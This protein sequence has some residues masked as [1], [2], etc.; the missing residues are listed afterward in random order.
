MTRHDQVLP[1]DPVPLGATWD[2]AGVNFALFSEGA[3]RIELCLFD[4]ERGALETARVALPE[5]TNG[6]WH[7]YLPG[8]RPGQL[9]GYRAYGPFDPGRGLRF[10]PHKLLVDPYARA[11]TGLVTVTTPLLCFP[12]RGGPDRDLGRDEVDSAP[13]APKGM[14]IDPHFDWGDDGSEDRA[15][16]TPWSRTVIYEAHVRGFTARHDALPA[17]VR[18]T[19]AALADERVTGYL[20]DLGVTAIELL[21][22]HQFVDDWR[23][24]ELGLRNYWGYNTLGFFAPH[25]GYAA[26]GTRGEQ[27]I[28]FKALVKA[29]HRAGLEVLLDVVYNHT[30]EGDRFGPTLSFRGLDNR[31]YYRLDPRHPRHYADHTGTGNTLNLGHPRA[32][33]LVMDSLRY[34]V[35]ELH[36]DGFRFDLATTLTRG[37]GEE[38]GTGSFL[39]VVAQDPILA[40]VK[41]IAEPWDIGP[42]GYRVGG[43]PGGWVEWNDK[44]RD[45]VRRFWRGDRGQIADLGSRLTGSSDLFAHNG[46]PPTASLNFVTAHDGFTLR[47]LVTYTA[48][49]N[50]ANGEDNR[51]GTDENY[52][53]NYG[54][55][56]PTDDPALRTIRAQQSRNLL[57]TLALSQGVPMLLHGD[58]VGR[59]QGGNNNAYCQDTPLAWQSWALDDEARALLTWTRRILA[60]RRA[61]PA[62]RRRSYF[63][64]R[65]L[66]SDPPPA[67]IWLRSDGAELGDAEWRDGALAGFGLWLNG[68][69]DTVPDAGVQAPAP[70][71]E[72]G[73][74]LLLLFNASERPIAFAMPRHDPAAWRFVL[75]TGQPDA[76]EGAAWD[77]DAYPLAA[78]TVAILRH[79]ATGDVAHGAT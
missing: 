53:A 38:P 69:G 19:Y 44:Y 3:E 71:S 28:E 10:N 66:G 52:S 62:L 34:W 60:L 59:S 56:G 33:Q 11:I 40:R 43:F 7:G 50:E 61:Q 74:T 1:G 37:P 2:G 63:H 67:I 26:G 39:D 8:L 32:L 17:A 5:R 30:G 75:D 77:D 51:D 65:P 9:Y 46:R 21:P 36:V 42:G 29:C 70:S 12:P 23:L 41:L 47:D 76:P 22:I 48:K 13:D 64:Y 16:R 54:Q 15:P 73:D 57:T 35:E 78:R 24:G 31:A 45:T 27:V 18:G 49:R 4:A 6:V 14:V 72:S 25:G 79:P 20:R 55:E 58:E 68:V